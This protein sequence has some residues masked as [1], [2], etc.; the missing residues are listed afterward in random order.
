MVQGVGK[1]VQ[2]TPCPHVCCYL[3]QTC[4]GGASDR[5]AAS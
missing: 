4:R 1:P 3:R 2:L 5:A